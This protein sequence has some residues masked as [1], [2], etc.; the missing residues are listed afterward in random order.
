[1]ISQAYAIAQGS[2]VQANKESFRLT[3]NSVKIVLL[4]MQFALNFP[5]A[6]LNKIQ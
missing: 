1:M 6:P 4:T 5:M 2:R 3:H